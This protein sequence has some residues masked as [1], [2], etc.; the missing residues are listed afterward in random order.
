MNKLIVP[1]MVFICSSHVENIV[2]IDPLHDQYGQLIFTTLV[3]RHGERSFEKTYPTDPY[4]NVSKYWPMGLG[5]LSLVGIEREYI[6]GKWLRDRYDRWLPKI[7]HVDDVFVQSSDFD[8]TIMSAQANLAGMYPSTFLTN[9][10]L[11]KVPMLSFQPI[12]IH[13]VPI[14]VDNK[15]SSFATC[16]KYLKEYNKLF[17]DSKIQKFYDQYQSMFE[18]IKN[19][20]QLEMGKNAVTS[21]TLL[22]DVLFVETTFNYTLPKWTKSIYPEPLLTVVKQNIELPTHTLAL[23]RLRGGA[24]LNDIVHRMV[25]KK[26]RTLNPNRMIWIYSAHDSTIINLLDSMELFNYAIVPYGAVLMFELR[27]NKT[28]SYVVTLSYRNS[29]KHEPHLLHLPGCD[30]VACE[31]D[32]FIDIIRPVLVTDWVAEC[33]NDNENNWFDRTGFLVVLIIAAVIVIII[34][35]L[36]ATNKMEVCVRRTDFNR[37]VFQ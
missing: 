18:Y 21:T 6:L 27:L 13:T 5:G 29:T 3:Y 34:L 7:Y 35:F 4:A 33:N 19:N 14:F 9:D 1:L 11:N 12:P 2:G 36:I 20:S 28:G 22:F 30:S 10:D 16:P 25:E 23:K 8:R 17:D 31:L 37:T 24:L 32:Q 15:I 26:N